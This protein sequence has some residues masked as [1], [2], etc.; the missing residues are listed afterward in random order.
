MIHGSS[1]KAPVCTFPRKTASGGDHYLLSGVAG[2]IVSQLEGNAMLLAL[3][4]WGHTAVC[5]CSFL[6]LI[7]SPS[8]MYQL[9]AVSLLSFFFLLSY[10]LFRWEHSKLKWFFVTVVHRLGTH[11]KCRVSAFPFRFDIPNF[12]A[13][14]VQAPISFT[15]RNSG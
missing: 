4:I 12:S 14:S 1:A 7:C 3:Y 6:S 8:D 13:V 15:Q 5:F 11:L 10:C 2:W 9:P